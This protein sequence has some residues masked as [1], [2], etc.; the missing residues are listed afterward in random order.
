MKLERAVKPLPVDTTVLV[1]A[2]SVLGLKYVQ[3][4]KGNSEDGFED[5]AT[6]PLQ[7]GD[8]RAGRV[9]RVPADVRRPDARGP[10]EE[11]AEFGNG[12]A[13]RGADL[14]RL[15]ETL[16]PLLRDITAG[17]AQPVGSR[18]PAGAPLPGARA[19]AP[20]ARA[21]RRAAGLAVPQ[22]RPTLQAFADVVAALPA[23]GHRRGAVGAGPCRPASSRAS[24][25]SCATA[26][27][28]SPSCA[29]APE[30]CA[31]AA[32]AAGRRDRRRRHDA[33][34]LRG[35][36]RR[37]GTTSS[38]NLRALTT[39]PLALVGLGDLTTISELAQPTI[40]HVAPA[41]D[42]VQLR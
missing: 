21:G 27:G 1:R 15:F 38:A 13:G 3:L 28:C 4:T 17:H 22:P 12:F 23:G 11:P 10:A 42:D 41:A 40:S 18:D 20:L 32:A 7:P 30:P 16:A 25:R 5:G 26:S 6:I 31:R 2:R 14:N 33:R 29:P 37:L 35:L 39:D 9:R 36:N 8:A 34:A 24:G 19:H